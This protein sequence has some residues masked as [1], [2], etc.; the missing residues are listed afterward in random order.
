M[1]E[2]SLRSWLNFFTN[3]F[4][5][6][7]PGSKHGTAIGAPI[8]HIVPKYVLHVVIDETMEALHDTQHTIALGYSK[9]REATYSSVYSAGWSTDINY[10]DSQFSLQLRKWKRKKA[11]HICNN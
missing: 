3:E 7:P 6:L 10:A 5:N 2:E 9:T 1:T 4:Q 8:L 11:E